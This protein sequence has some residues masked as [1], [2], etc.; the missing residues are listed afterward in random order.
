MSWDVDLCI[1]AHDDARPIRRAV[2]SVLDHTSA[3][4]RVSVVAHNIDPARIAASI[5]DL[6]DHPAVRVLSLQDGIRSPAGPFNA[7]LDAAE[8][9]FTAVMGSDDSLAPGAIDAWLARARREDADVVIARLRHAAGGFIATPPV[10]PLRTRSLDPVRDRLSY[11]SAP[12]GLVRRRRFGDVRFAEGVAVGEDV[13]YVTALWF[14]GAR[15]SYAH[16]DPAYLVHDDAVE[17]TTLS[18]RPVRAELAFIT[19]LL[20]S[21]TVIALP[22]AA[23]TAIAVKLLRVHVFGVI[24]NRPDAAWWTVDEREA[25]AE[26]AST[27]RGT[28]DVDASLSRND[29]RLCAIIAD[30]ATGPNALFDA[31]AARRRFAHPDSIRTA[32]LTDLLRRDAPLRY[33][34]ATVV[35]TRG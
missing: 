1:A 32:R 11:R 2:E 15:L 4:V 23:R 25:L 22:A 16:G 24:V 30:P 21:P 6:A 27:V 26:I 9:E 18:T 35:Q 13:S 31:S 28:G 20:A 8:A 10:R 17:R 3:R 12:L 34:I 7:G 33:A 5:G 14:S 29:L 19:H